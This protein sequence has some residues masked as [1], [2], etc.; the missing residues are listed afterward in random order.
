MGI[1]ALQ[2]FMETH[3]SSACVSVDLLKISRGFMPEKRGR[4]QDGGRFCL[5]V[6]AESCLDRLYGGF[7]SD[8]VCGGQ[9]NRMLSFLQNLIQA[10]HNANL[11]MVVFFNGA[12]E[13][14]KL[15]DWFADQVGQK[16]KVNMVLRHLNNKGTP[17]PKVWWN[18]PVFLRGALRMALRHLGVG[19]AC[20]MD[21]HLQE[22]I[23]FSR[24]H[25]MQGIVAQDSVYAI[26]DPPRYF[27]SHNL[28]L[29][30]KGSLETKEYIMDELAKCLDLNP[31]RFCIF[32]ALL[33]NH[34]LPDENLYEFVRE[35][36]NKSDESG[37]TVK[38]TP[39]NAIRA[40]VD[41]VRS[42]ADVS[43]LD[44]VG[45]EV[46]RNSKGNKQEL[47]VKFKKSVQYYMN[48]TE[49]GFL[50]YRPKGTISTRQ[51]SQSIQNNQQDLSGY[52]DPNNPQIIVD[53]PLLGAVAN[54]DNNKGK[55]SQ[56]KQSAKSLQN[57]SLPSVTPEVM[58]IASDRHQK[59]LMSPWIY[60]VL[61][62]GE[63]KMYIPLEDDQ[64]R[65]L[66]SCMDFYRP[67]RQTVYSVLLNLNKHMIIHDN[68]GKD[69]D[70]NESKSFDV[71]I[72]EWMVC[73]GG[74]SKPGFKIVM[75]KPVNWKTPSIERM[76][77]G[78]Q[79]DDKTRRLRA[80]L[81]CLQSDTPLMLN[82]QYVPQHLLILCCVLRY[83]LQAG[84]ILQRQELDAFLAMS[85]SPLL[86]DVQTMQ[87][88]K[89]PQVNVRGVHLASLFM[90]GIEHAIF[91]NDVCG[92]PIPWTMCCPWN[93]FDGKL[94]HFKLL[95]ANN[96][97]PLIDMC[98]GQ[99][100]Q[101]LRV[102][103]MRQ[104]IMEE[105]HVEFARPL[106]PTASLYTSYPL[107]PYAAPPFPYRPAGMR[108]MPQGPLGPVGSKTSGRGRGILGRSPIDARGGQ[109]EIAGVVV[110][111]WGPNLSSSGRGRGGGGGATNLAPRVM[112]VGG[113]KR[114]RGMMRGGG[115]MMRGPLM[116]NPMMRGPM[117][118]E[119]MMVGHMMHG[120]MGG[121]SMS[122]PIRGRGMP[123]YGMGRGLRM[124][125]PRYYSR[126]RGGVRGIRR[127][128]VRARPRI[129][130]FR[131]GK[132]GKPSR[133]R[134]TT[135]EASEGGSAVVSVKV[136]SLDK[137]CTNAAAIYEDAEEGVSDAI[138]K[139]LMQNGIQ[140]PDSGIHADKSGSDINTSLN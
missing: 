50:K 9:W 136:E 32:A 77:L 20:S 57:I 68:Q 46:F 60:Q 36:L 59:G 65:E 25:G 51:G 87:D 119:D 15:N 107:P 14:E 58:R 76:W 26:F 117:T 11:D 135:V 91:A 17:P 53:P 37:K 81:T 31:N 34:I 2:D 137:K 62:Q 129:A 127:P 132:S 115:P 3:C 140:S 40:V 74:N 75:A 39:D 95:K 1:K 69:K 49:D 86:H 47:I 83:M 134:G 92:A 78:Q 23:G 79:P 82:T 110:G 88:L 48:G 35:L 45:A 55:K 64:S 70:K 38:P 120:M 104:A 105:L 27:S 71:P 89:L 12:L 19:V 22:V 116:R 56:N 44:L 100:D 29:T 123:M 97:T 128:A 102:E 101:V 8:W 63:V 118:R 54:E 103:R 112:S 42:L 108:A 28:K 126:G 80:F 13:S 10:C 43:N 4:F 73:H 131:R 139:A 114:G 67:I 24:E 125:D 72:K 124:P 61:S 111:S 85:V 121:D 133:G 130:A 7:F 33:G 113:S 106:L 16:R 5:V 66:P 109:L 93:F 122:R 98:D 18:P 99:V 52:G 21:D 138:G 90:S 94:F 84:R 41:F 30:Y 96:N 6:D